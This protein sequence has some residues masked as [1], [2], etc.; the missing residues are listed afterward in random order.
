MHI[1]QCEADQL[2]AQDL[3]RFE[4]T[5][6]D[7]ITVPLDQCEFDALVSFMPFNTGAGALQESTL[8]KRLNRG[9]PKSAV[10]AEELPRWVNGAN[11]SA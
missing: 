1:T 8:R 10:F 9:D 11:A 7:M 5:V 2:L 6:T 3:K 4:K